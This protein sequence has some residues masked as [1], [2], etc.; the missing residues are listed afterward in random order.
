MARSGLR[1]GNLPPRVPQEHVLEAS[2]PQC[3][4][5]FPCKA[6]G[7]HPQSSQLQCSV[8]PGREACRAS[9]PGIQA[10]L[11]P[12]TAQHL[13]RTTRCLLNKTSARPPARGSAR[14]GLQEGAQGR[15]GESVQRAPHHVQPRHVHRAPGTIKGLLSQ[16]LGTRLEGVQSSGDPW[17][18]FGTNPLLQLRQPACLSAAPTPGPTTST[19]PCSLLQ[20]GPGAGELPDQLSCSTSPP[21]KCWSPGGY[22]SPWCLGQ[23]STVC[24]TFAFGA[25]FSQKNRLFECDLGRQQATSRCW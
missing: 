10:P 7:T 21:A 2:F 15:G 1:K 9:P 5:G 11:G 12:T 14:G 6:L 22:V 4:A 8:W 16:E 20:R 23:M 18:Y 3:P 19:S 24:T 25:R 13:P 17:C